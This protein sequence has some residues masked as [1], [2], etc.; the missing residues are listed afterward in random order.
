MSGRARCSFILSLCMDVSRAE[1]SSTLCTS[2]EQSQ[3][4]GAF[5]EQQV[6]SRE[7]SAWYQS[8]GEAYRCL[9]ENSAA[10]APLS[11]PIRNQ[12]PATK[13]YSFCCICAVP[14]LALKGSLGCQQILRWQW[15]LLWLVFGAH[16]TSSSIISPDLGVTLTTEPHTFILDSS[17]RLY[18]LTR[19]HQSRTSA[20]KSVEFS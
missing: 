3:S 11:L 8:P 19:L 15:W 10:P 12:W 4:A 6:L 17:W 18:V 5:P 20:F 14:H 7:L 1:A 16:L 2:Q 13:I 9:G